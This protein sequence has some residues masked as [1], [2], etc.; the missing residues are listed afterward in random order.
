MMKLALLLSVLAIALFAACG[1]QAD[2]GTQAPAEDTDETAMVE[3]TI[4][5]GLEMWDIYYILIDPSDEIWSEDRLGEEDILAPGE[6]FTI[7]IEEG[8]WDM[9][10]EDEDGD[11]YTLWQVE[12][13][14]EDYQWNVTID[15][16]DS[17]WGEDEF[18]EPQIIETGE[19]STHI[20]ITNDLQGWDIYWVYVDPADASRSDDRLGSNVLFQDDQ[21]IVR[22]DPGTYYIQVEDQDGD[23]YTLRE[24]EVD[25][26]GF[27]WPV[28]LG[29]MDPISDVEVHE[30]FSLD[31]GDGTAPVTVVND[32]GG[33]DI[34]NVYVDPSDGPWGDDRLGTEILTESN[35]ITI[36]VD[37]GTYDMRVQDVDG[38]TYTLWE[39]DVDENGYEWAVAL[40][41]MD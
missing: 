8:T 29:D 3:I 21:I 19:G 9:T 12:I 6:S 40:E 4:T 26:A 24:V 32:L 2:E 34:F 16:L 37:P 1:E 22:V 10:V 33:W 28:T 41:D 13:G 25:A 11:T 7:E 14:P 38:D 17:G 35:D 5:N 18:I 20:A 30:G 23:T 36:W 15:D 39:I 27:E 31:T